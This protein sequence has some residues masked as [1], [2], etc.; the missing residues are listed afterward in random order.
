MLPSVSMITRLYS[1]RSVTGSRS[2]TGTGVSLVP[3]VL[4]VPEK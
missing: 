2:V 4:L 1:T 3:G